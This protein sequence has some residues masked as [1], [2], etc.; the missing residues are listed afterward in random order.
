MMSNERYEVFALKYAERNS[1][2]RNDSF[3]FDD[4]HTSQHDMDYFIWV[5]RNAER[6]VLIDTGYD[7]A[8]AKRRNRPILNDPTEMLGR[9]GIKPM[10]V[11]DLVVTHLHYDHAGGLHLFEH[12][13]FH[14]QEAE[15]GFAVSGCMCHPTL[16]AP[17]TADH[18]C[19]TVRQLYNGKVTFYT[20]SGQVAPGIRVHH[21]GGHSSGL[22]IVDIDTETG[23]VIL[24]SD[25]SHYY[26]NYRKAKLFPIVVNPPAMLEG[27][28]KLR[29]FEEQGY[30][31]V[32]GHDP[33]VLQRSPPH[34][35]GIVKLA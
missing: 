29:S 16:R 28:A 19:T 9:L 14:I 32:P 1:R 25:A 5:A 23:P 15:L 20:G 18:V 27:F 3:M 13:Q 22:Q 6:T 7:T 11:T 21:V 17:F 12:A 2:T 24:A 33:Q 8:E 4:D 35:P 10:D 30:T 34:L 31:V 26:E